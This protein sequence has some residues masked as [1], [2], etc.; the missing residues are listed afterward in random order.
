MERNVNWADSPGKLASVEMIRQMPPHPH[1]H[2]P[3]IDNLNPLIRLRTL[4]TDPF[5][6][7]EALRISGG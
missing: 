4:L 7:D 1:S 3:M 6:L 2:S 5:L